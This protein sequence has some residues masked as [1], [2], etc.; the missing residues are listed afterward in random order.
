VTDV[1]AVA[2]Q[3]VSALPE[4]ADFSDLDEFLY[5]RAMVERG[6]DDSRAGRTVAGGGGARDSVRPA[7][8]SDVGRAR[9][10]GAC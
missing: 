8:Y 3:V 10:R 1:K 4:D 6:R 7:T 9:H 2:L 5:E